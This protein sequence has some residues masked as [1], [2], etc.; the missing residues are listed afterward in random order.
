MHRNHRDLLKKASMKVVN[1]IRNT[2]V[3]INAPPSKAHTLRALIISSLTD[4]ASTIYNPLLGQDQLNVIECLKKL[5]VEIKEEDDKLIVYGTGGRYTPICEQLNVGESGVGM[6]FLT[7][8][9]CLSNKP[10]VITGA[11]RIT[12]RPILE[13]VKRPATIGMQNRIS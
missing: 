11:K 9:V 13:V 2:D 5:G 7:S 1:K 12:E 10:I 8:A 6:N 4:G 3:T